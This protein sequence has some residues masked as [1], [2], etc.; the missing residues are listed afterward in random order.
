MQDVIIIGGGVIGCA[1]AR[2]LSRYKLDV[3]LLE[4]HGDVGRGTSG[5]NSGIVHAGYDPKPGTFKAR[6]NVKGNL[7]Y[8]QLAKGA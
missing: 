4:A 1:I 3:L 6:F 7:M 5:A 2:E 8:D